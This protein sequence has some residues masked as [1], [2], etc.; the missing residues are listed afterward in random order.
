MKQSVLEGLRY[1]LGEGGVTVLQ[2]RFDLETVATQPDK[3]H[4]MLHSLFE[5]TGGSVLERAVIKQLY[6]NIGERFVESSCSSLQS[7]IEGAKEIF[8][9]Q[10]ARRN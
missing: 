2:R 8:K 1:S 5:N 3:L 7:C 6:E 9:A 4:S 10:D